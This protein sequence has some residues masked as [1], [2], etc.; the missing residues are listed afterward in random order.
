M[1]IVDSVDAGT[2]AILERYGFD[3]PLFEELRARVADG[4]LSPATNA[5][6]GTVEPLPA[7]QIARL[8]EPGD[9]A[10]EEAREAGKA[11]LTRGEVAAAVLNGGMAT[12]FG[13]VVKGIVDAYGGRSFLEWKL[14]DAERAGVPLVVMNSFATDEATRYFVAAHGLPRPIFF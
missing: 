7:D 6:S 11:A 12:R 9:P 3:E 1:S 8:P 2:R 14:L 10:Y 13:G 4:S 5:V